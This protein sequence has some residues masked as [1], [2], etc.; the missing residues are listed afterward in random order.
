MIRRVNLALMETVLA[1]H[2]R[3]TVPHPLA[4]YVND[5]M[6]IHTPPAG[7]GQEREY[8]FTVSL[9]GQED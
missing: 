6:C 7:D 4:E 3:R 5:W 2:R 1:E 8:S 9:N